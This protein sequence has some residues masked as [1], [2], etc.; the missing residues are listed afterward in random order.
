[1]KRK[2]AG[3]SL[4]EI[5]LVIAIIGLLSSVV[6]GGIRGAITSSRVAKAGHTQ[7]Q[8]TRAVELY[9]ADM[10]FYP[11]DVNRGWDPGFSTPL[12]SNPDIDAG[13]TPGGGFNVPGTDCSHCPA[14]WQ[15]LVAILWNGPYF[16][17]WPRYTPW[18][19]KYDYNYWGSDT[20]R[21]GCPLSAGIYVGVQGDY[22]NSN[23]ITTTGENKMIDKGFDAE[24]CV[25]GESQMFLY[26]L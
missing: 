3:F 5:V 7:R 16:N 12:P 18:D 23:T 24:A 2:R 13:E 1:M 15:D 11:P 4:I 20:D 14:N 8:L 9:Y 26:D 25:N 17:E 21:Y 22:T 10:G 6:L 19:G